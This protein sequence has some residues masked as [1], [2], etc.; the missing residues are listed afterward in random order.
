MCGSF[1]VSV[2]SSVHLDMI[3]TSVVLFEGYG[4]CA[5]VLF[6]RPWGA[7]WAASTELA[8]FRLMGR[9]SCVQWSRSS[10]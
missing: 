8:G 9:L 5:I 2:P 4:M 6:K 10:A 7:L 3:Y 1:W